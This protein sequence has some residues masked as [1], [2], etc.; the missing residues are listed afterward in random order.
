VL[1]WQVLGGGLDVVQVGSQTYIRSV[2]GEFDTDKNK[3]LELA[4]QTG[5][6]SAGNNII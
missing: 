6:I 2:P 3:V 1:T 5:C 4:Q